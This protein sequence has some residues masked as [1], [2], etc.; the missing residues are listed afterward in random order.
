MSRRL[1]GWQRLWVIV[2]VLLLAF[3]AL[4]VVS[5]SPN[6]DPD[7]LRQLNSP[8][9]AAYRSFDGHA[10]GWK[11]GEPIKDR[12]NCGD[13]ISYQFVHEVNLHSVQDYKRH[14][15]GRQIRVVVVGFF[16]WV[17]IVAMIYL[18]GVGVAWVRRGFA[19]KQT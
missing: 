15:H 7:I 11:L 8:L 17:V 5:V 14:L 19:S 4:I 9:C 16:W 10:D 13:L 18:F 2:A 3:V 12:D 1:N 6:E